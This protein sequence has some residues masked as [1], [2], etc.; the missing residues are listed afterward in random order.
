MDRGSHLSSAARRVEDVI[1]LPLPIGGAQEYSPLTM[2]GE[3]E[4]LPL[5]LRRAQDYP[6]LPLGERI[7]VRGEAPPVVEHCIYS[8]TKSMK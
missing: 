7:E 2:G 1:F 6:P 5:P 3:K 8:D 4:Y